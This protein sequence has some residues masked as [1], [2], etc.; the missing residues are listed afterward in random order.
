MTHLLLVT[1]TAHPGFLVAAREAKLSVIALVDG[2][3]AHNRKHGE[4]LLR[5][6]FATRNIKAAREAA[7]VATGAKRL[8]DFAYIV[9]P[10]LLPSSPPS[11][12]LSLSISLLSWSA[13]FFFRAVVLFRHRNTNRPCQ[14]PVFGSLSP[15]P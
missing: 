1:R 10:S 6:V 3:G 12:S 15:S 14:P 8:R 7:G 4:A 5:S 13:F 11:L 2:A 9:G